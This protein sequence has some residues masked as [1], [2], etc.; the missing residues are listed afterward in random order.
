[1]AMKGEKEMVKKVYPI[2]W[3]KKNGKWLLQ[4]VT[5][6]GN[7]QNVLSDE[8]IALENYLAELKEF[9]NSMKQKSH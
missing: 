5:S 8:K 6:G 2:T 4:Y 3:D 1:M 9:R 7:I